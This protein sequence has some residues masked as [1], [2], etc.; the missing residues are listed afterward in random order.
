MSDELTPA[1]FKKEW[2]AGRRPVLIDVRRQD[3]W[4]TCNLSEYGA[5]HIPLDQFEERYREIPKD[6][7]VV[8][9]CKGGGRSARAQRFLQSQGYSR[10]QNLAGGIM[11]WADEVDS[12]KTKY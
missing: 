10:V 6:A 11:Q 3:E 5:K 1:E 7:D 12:S 8:I 2:D 9:H 4:D